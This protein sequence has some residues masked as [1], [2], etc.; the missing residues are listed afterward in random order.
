MN[1]KIIF[2]GTESYSID[3]L[4]SLIDAG[5]PI[6][7]VVTKA[8]APSGRGHN[9]TEPPIKTFAKLHDIPVWQ[10]DKVGDLADEIAKLQPV[11]GVLV[12]YGKIIPQRIIDLFTPGIIN[13]HPSLLPRWRGPSPIETAIANRDTETGVTLIQLNAEMDAGAIYAQRKITLRQT[14]TK[15]ELYQTLFSLGSQMLLDYLPD[16][17]TGSLQ[18]TPQPTTGVTYC[19][20][21]SKNMSLLNPETM[22]ALEAEAHVRAYTDF[23][24]SKIQLADHLVIVTKA[25]ISTAQT[26]LDLLFKDGQFLAIDELIAPSGKTMSGDAF[27]RGYIDQN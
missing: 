27:R 17:M 18:P 2:F 25:H 16:I 3:T 19:S 22:T 24:R 13:V 11:T 6:A 23:P 20:L 1:N 15:P 12:A 10:P 21:M 7:S 4:K 9:L 26:P 8:D 5:Y 14:E